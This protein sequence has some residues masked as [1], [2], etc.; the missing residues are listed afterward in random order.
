MRF[1]PFFLAS[2]SLLLTAASCPPP[3][4]ET[5]PT[6]RTAY[7]HLTRGR[8]R[9]GL[10]GYESASLHLVRA[11]PAERPVWPRAFMLYTIHEAKAWKRVL[12]RAESAGAEYGLVSYLGFRDSELLL[13][14]AVQGILID[15]DFHARPGRWSRVPTWTLPV[16]FRLCGDGLMRKARSPEPVLDA[17][18]DDIPIMAADLI[19]RTALATAACRFYVR[20][21]EVSLDQRVGDRGCRACF[22]RSARLVARFQRESA[23]LAKEE[24][25]RQRRLDDARRWE[26]RADDA[27]ENCT[28]RALEWVT[29]EEFIMATVQEHF[30]SGLKAFGAAIEARS[31]R[32][33][34]ARA[35]MGYRSALEHFLV[36]RA[37]KAELNREERARM[38]FVERAVRGVYRLLTRPG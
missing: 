13:P 15:S 29:G 21:W 12:T 5:Y 32:G 9:E 23:R 4:E 2:L 30:E 3:P 25:D 17:V 10:D 1:R 18:G 31:G 20:A 7:R 14:D 36:A 19:A 16:F 34:R 24:S 22:H 37:F 8:V 27:Q 35:E 38:E 11:D 33:T 28:I 26:R 6:I